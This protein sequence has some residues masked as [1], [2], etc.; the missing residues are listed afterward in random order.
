MEKLQMPG[1]GWKWSNFPPSMGTKDHKNEES[2]TTYV[3]YD[4]ERVF[5]ILLAVGKF[6][7]K[8]PYKS[9]V[10]DDNLRRM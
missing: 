8:N 2:V 9:D 4:D 1:S 3:I 5:S 7:N 10:F 6:W